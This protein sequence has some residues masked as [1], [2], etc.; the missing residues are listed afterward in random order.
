MPCWIIFEDD[1]REKLEPEAKLRLIASLRNASL[2]FCRKGST[3]RR[4]WPAAQPPSHRSR[5]CMLLS[6]RW[7]SCSH[8][9]A[10]K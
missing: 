2:F 10:V 1:H 9:I 7:S 6:N 5:N 4:N 8:E 3:N